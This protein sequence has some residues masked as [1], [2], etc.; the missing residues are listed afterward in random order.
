MQVMRREWI[1]EG[2]PGAK[3]RDEDDM[4]VERRQ[5]GDDGGDDSGQRRA[6]GYGDGDGDGSAGVEPS[7]FGDGQ[8]I[9]SGGI[10][11]DGG[12]DD[13]D[14][15]VFDPHAAIPSH[16]G[17]APDN[18]P[19]E[20]DALDALLDETE[21]SRPPETRADDPGD[22]FDTFDDDWEAMNAYDI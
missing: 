15:F 5:D 16:S 2:K 8:R 11:G 6:E 14:L 12:G 10:D 13:D 17:P 21:A 9:T 4:D 20:E 7:L 1:D 19:A 18:V 22:T 3:R